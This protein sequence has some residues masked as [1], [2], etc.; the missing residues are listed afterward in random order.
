MK[1]EHVTTHASQLVERVAQA[2]AAAAVEALE[3]NKVPS[4]FLFTSTFVHVHAAEKLVPY[5]LRVVQTLDLPV[6]MAG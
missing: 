1:Q 5:V 2:K 3:C 4:D 6:A